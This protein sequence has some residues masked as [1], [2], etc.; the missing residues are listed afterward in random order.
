MVIPFK[1]FPRVLQEKDYNLMKSDKLSQLI[2]FAANTAECSIINI[3]L[4]KGY[5]IGAFLIIT[6]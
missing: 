1:D 5:N 2:N 6:R 3:V 4:I